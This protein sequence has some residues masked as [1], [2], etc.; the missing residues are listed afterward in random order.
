MS[1]LACLRCTLS[2][3]FRLPVEYKHNPK[4]NMK[5]SVGRSIIVMALLRLRLPFLDTTFVPDCYF[6]TSEI[7]FDYSE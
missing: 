3:L 6:V 7:S 1:F 5:M 4:M 2:A